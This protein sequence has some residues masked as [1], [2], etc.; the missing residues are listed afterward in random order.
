MCKTA[1]H[2]CIGKMQSFPTCHW[3]HLC[4]ALSQLDKCH[5]SSDTVLFNTVVGIIMRTIPFLF[6]ASGS[7]GKSNRTHNPKSAGLCS[8]RDQICNWPGLRSRLFVNRTIKKS[9]GAAKQNKKHVLLIGQKINKSTSV[10][11][12]YLQNRVALLGFLFAVLNIYSTTMG[13]SRG[14]GEVAQLHRCFLQE[15]GLKTTASVRE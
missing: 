2:L 14:A 15:T 10:S 5:G 3:G 6:S 9:F 8:V 1:G 4:E 12:Y 13:R 7:S 11:V